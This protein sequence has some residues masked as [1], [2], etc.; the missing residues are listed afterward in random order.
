MLDAV[1]GA[2]T[3]AE[4]TQCRDS[5]AVLCNPRF[6]A[7]CDMSYCLGPF[8]ANPC[9]FAWTTAYGVELV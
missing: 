5:C 2:G 8:C 9:K 7:S 4:P 1:L 3:C 6:D